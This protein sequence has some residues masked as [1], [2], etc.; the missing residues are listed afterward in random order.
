MSTK[1]PKFKVVVLA[2]VPVWMIPGLEYLYRTGVYA[3][4][5][6]A[7]IPEFEKF[8]NLDMH[9]ICMSKQLK[10]DMEKTAWNQTFHILRRGKKS[11]SMITA[12]WSERRSIQKM[13]DKINPDLVHAWGTEDVFGLAGTNR[14]NK[15]KLFTIQ[16]CLGACLETMAKPPLL[17]RIQAWYENRTVRAYSEATGESSLAVRH[18]ERINPDLTTHMIDY[19]VSKE[20]FKAKW[21]PG[22]KPEIIFVGSVTE[23]KGI[24]DL[25]MVM[26]SPELQEVTLKIAGDGPLVSELSETCGNNIEWLGRLKRQEL[27]EHMERAW[28]LVA[29]T[30]ADTGPTVVK[31]ARVMGMPVVTTTAA[32]ASVYV[33]AENSCCVVTPGDRPALRKAIFHLCQSREKCMKMGSNGWR[34]TREALN[35]TTAATNF[36]K[37]YKDLLSKA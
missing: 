7:L 34:E 24:R 26:K 4:W 25:C 35:T 27:I 10:D 14:K 37:L 20:F 36:F 8:E 5:L 22:E 2:D 17:M 3:T 6:E 15:I 18:L 19:G 13:I 30:Y 28:V 16:G 29:P 1:H 12:Y 21:N 31:E 32:G 9:W 11:L 23:A 33:K